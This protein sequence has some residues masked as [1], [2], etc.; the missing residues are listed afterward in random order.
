[1]IVA[2][3]VAALYDGVAGI[4][5]L[6]GRQSVYVVVVKLVA[7]I[8]WVNVRGDGGPVVLS[9][10]DVRRAGGRALRGDLG[11]VRRRERP[12]D[13]ACERQAVRG[14]RARRD[15][16]G[17]GR[18]GRKRSVRRQRRDR[19]REL[20]VT[21]ALTGDPP[22]GV[23]VKV[24]AVRVV[25]IHRPREGRGR[26]REGADACTVGVFAVTVGG[27]ADWTVHV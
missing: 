3:F 12:A 19:A 9:G 6:S 18:R 24:E 11:C 23:S 5:V 21:V 26:G 4:C 7:S 17:V 1:V 22:L 10:R 13:G 27:V 25:V 20:H 8:A 15:L 2:V 14:L 16:R